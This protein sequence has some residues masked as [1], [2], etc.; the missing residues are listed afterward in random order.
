MRFENR[1]KI[2][3]PTTPLSARLSRPQLWQGLVARAEQPELFVYGLEYMKVLARGTHWLERELCL[4]GGLLVRD[5]VLFTPLNSVHY[6]TEAGTGFAASSLSMHIEEPQ[7]E[8][9]YVQFTYHT[10]L[11]AE[12]ENED[13]RFVAYIQEA[14]KQADRDTIR[15]LRAWV[16]G[17]LTAPE[18]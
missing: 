15:S 11:Q 5:R 6:A 9:L 2:C 18:A 10:G 1:I 13:A 14:Y 4:P 8:H 16:R 7:P 12:A 3:A 17:E